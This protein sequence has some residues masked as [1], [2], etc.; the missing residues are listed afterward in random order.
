MSL[1]SSL[2]RFGLQAVSVFLSRDSTRRVPARS[3]RA[4]TIGKNFHVSFDR[5]VVQT[6]PTSG[7]TSVPSGSVCSVPSQFTVG[8]IDARFTKTAMMKFHTL[9]YGTIFSHVKR[10]RGHTSTKLGM[11][12]HPVTGPVAWSLPN[13]TPRFGVSL[14]SSPGICA[15]FHGIHRTRSG[16]TSW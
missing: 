15:S 3:T 10:P 2:A 16:G 7:A 11:S 1:P 14:V 12:Q 5:D 8:G 13:P 9:R 4:L 6:F